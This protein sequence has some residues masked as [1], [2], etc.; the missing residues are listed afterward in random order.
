[1]QDTVSAEI[2]PVGIV[3]HCSGWLK[4]HFLNDFECWVYFQCKPEVK[5]TTAEGGG[6]EG[7]EEEEEID[8]AIAQA[9][10]ALSAL[11]T[12]DVGSTFQSLS[13]LFVMV[14]VSTAEPE[15]TH[16]QLCYLFAGLGGYSEN[17]NGDGGFSIF[18]WWNQGSPVQGFVEFGHPQGLAK[19][20]NPHYIFV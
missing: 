9:E 13:M 7:E 10:S 15:V 12:K 18:I 8:P 19:S 4:M 3:S 16:S 6:K 14:Q 17:I 5:N 2:H 20:G 1:M 11:D